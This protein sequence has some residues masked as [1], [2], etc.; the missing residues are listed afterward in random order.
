MSSLEIFGPV[1]CVYGY[2]SVDEAVA[3]SNAV[4]YSFQASVFTKEW[5]KA[6]NIG[7]QL[8]ASAVMVNESSTFRVDW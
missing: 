4:P 2:D 5:E 8:N 3:L 7:R 1:A 6:F